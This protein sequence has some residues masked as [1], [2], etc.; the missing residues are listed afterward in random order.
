MGG[1]CLWQDSNPH[2]P[3]RVLGTQPGHLLWHHPCPALPCPV[4]DTDRE[5]VCTPHLD[6]SVVV[7]GDGNVGRCQQLSP[8]LAH[9]DHLLLL[10]HPPL[11]LKL[12]TDRR[13][14]RP[15]DRRHN[16]QLLQD[17]RHV[18]SSG[19]TLHGMADRGGVLS[20]A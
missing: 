5:T 13:R 12:Q 16:G 8:H 1:Y 17:L 9:G 11:G 14:S 20:G 18:P 6:L 2:P 15:A 3:F 10:L 4:T 7:D 19:C